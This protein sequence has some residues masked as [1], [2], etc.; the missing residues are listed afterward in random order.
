MPK[1][2]LALGLLAPLLLACTETVPESGVEDRTRELLS[3]MHDDVGEVDCPENLDAEVGVTMECSVSI[4]GM[5]REVT[6]EVTEVEDGN[7]VWK[8][9]VAE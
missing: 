3:E 9:D 7:A 1:R 6:L 4:G 8:V 2:T 5:S